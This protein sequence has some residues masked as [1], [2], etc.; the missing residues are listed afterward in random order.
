MG[1]P[2]DEVLE[3]ERCRVDMESVIGVVNRST[4]KQARFIT[5]A[6]F[7]FISLRPKIGEVSMYTDF[8]GT[9]RDPKSQGLRNLNH[10]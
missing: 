8:H 2:L 10:P 7:K 1:K 6:C 4:F 5:R 9:F 3:D